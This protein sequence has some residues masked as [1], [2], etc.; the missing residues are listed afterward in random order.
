M[1]SLRALAFVCTALALAAC[2]D[3][4]AGTDPAD[5]A[6]E[7]T[8]TGVD[9]ATDARDDATDAAQDAGAD[10]AVDTAVDTSLDTA[11]AGA[12]APVV[13]AAEAGPSR[14]ADVGSTVVLDASA[15]TGAVQYVWDFGDGRDSG[16]PSADP[17]AEVAYDAPGRYRA[18]LTAYGADG[19]TRTDVAV[20][21]VTAPPTFAPR[22][23]SPI[24]RQP[25]A[26]R[27]AVVSEDS[28]ELVVVEQTGLDAWSV[29]DRF[30][31]CTGPRTV[32]RLGAGWLV[33]CPTVDTLTW[34][35]DDGRRAEVIL[36]WGA[37]PFGVIT[38]DDTRA[39]ITLQGTGELVVV[40]VDGVV[41]P[42][43]DPI[44]ALPD[45]RDV[46]LLPDGR[47]LVT[48]W[49]SP[50]DRGELVRVD[51]DTGALEPVELGFDDL[52][53]SD[54]ET[55]GV[56]SYLTAPAV[57]PTDG[58][59]AV[60]STQANIGQGLVSNGEALTHETTV[61]AVVSF[62]GATSTTDDIED[63][64]QFDDRGLPGAAVFSPRGDWLYV[65]MRGSRTLERVDAFTGDL[66]G[67]VFD[68]GYAPDGLA[69]SSDGRLAVVRASLS[70]EVVVYDISDLSELPRPLVRVP[71]VDV[72]PLEPVVLRGKQLFND[73]FDIRLA[74]DS[75][76]ACAHCHLDGE[77]DHRT[78]DFTDRGEGL[79]NT[80]SLLGRAG[81][82]HGPVHWSANFD[83][84]QD[85]EHDLRGPFG[86]LGLMADAD[87]EADGRDH[88]LG[89]P[90]AGVSDDLDALAAYVA[91]LDATPRSPF[92]T[93]DGDLTTA[94]QR[95]RTVFER[96]DVGC[97]GCHA[98]PNYTDSAFVDGE[99][100]LHDVGTLLDTSGERLGEGPLVGLD[101]PTLLGLHNNAPYLHDGRA[102][103]VRDV[104]TTW[105][106]DDAHGVTST[107]T[108]DELDD[109]V[110]YLLSL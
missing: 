82:G 39:A 15:S 74:R 2:G 32:D 91:S 98:G 109:L 104:L 69:L 99:P 42:V 65:L 13:L 60:A 21:T 37:R 47:V 53:A 44:A 41:L 46:A 11:D 67:N 89:A 51:L 8:D 85:F 83:E 72:E 105:N 97:A 12:D 100:V 77:A 75:Y 79:R 80:I 18:T 78:W 22:A 90:K 7:A 14:Y 62:I 86:G 36:P 95:G 31:T 19:G 102:A 70:R 66:S 45:A 40:S 73:S 23:S 56:P 34:R 84:I 94:A 24:Q 25:D 58:R 4:G 10:T 64:K 48:R 57:S 93:S 55:G 17:I 107:L 96:E 81:M 38:L 20:I 6:V 28:D 30:D 68:I 61:R 33:A 26:E 54:T 27:Y 35:G 3:D 108:D 50:D 101:T 49:R 43:G 76:I 9:S 106:P 92:R 63:R 5:V 71:Y 1:R 110:T 87:F 103:T 59:V 16:A 52:G 88:P 29:T